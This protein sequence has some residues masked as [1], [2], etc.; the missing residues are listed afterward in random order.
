MLSGV[1]AGRVDLD[2]IRMIE[3][4]SSDGLV[5]KAGDKLAV[6]RESGA[7]RLDGDKPLQDRLPGLVHGAHSSLPEAFEHFKFTQLMTFQ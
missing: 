2:Q 4:S 6:H 1:F 5:V 7:E 3:R